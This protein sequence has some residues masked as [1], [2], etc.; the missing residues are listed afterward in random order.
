MTRKRGSDQHP[1]GP[2]SVARAPGQSRDRGHLRVVPDLPLLLPTLVSGGDEDS[3]ADP[4][5]VLEM[6]LS[7]E[8]LQSLSDRGFT[9]QDALDGRVPGMDA[10]EIIAKA[11]DE[12][13]GRTG[14][15]SPFE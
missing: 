7:T 13:G 14:P 9:L 5:E 3:E 1:A 4:W 8:A 6:C 15:W 10:D 12:T 2:G 11:M